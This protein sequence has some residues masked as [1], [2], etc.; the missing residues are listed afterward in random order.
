MDDLENIENI[1]D[2]YTF[3]GEVVNWNATNDQLAT[4]VMF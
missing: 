1:L 3:I 4:Y 2:D